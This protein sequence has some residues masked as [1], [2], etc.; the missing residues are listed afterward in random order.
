MDTYPILTT[1]STARVDGCWTGTAYDLD[2][3]NR[4]RLEPGDSAKVKYYVVNYSE[5]DEPPEGC[6][7]TETFTFWEEYWMDPSSP[8]GLDDES[9]GWGFKIHVEDPPA[10]QVTQLQPFR[11]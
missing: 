1:G 7:P 3:F 5:Y 9:F 10:I 8:A 4:K 11:T 2:E 6:W